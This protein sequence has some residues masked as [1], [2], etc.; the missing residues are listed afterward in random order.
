MSYCSSCGQAVGEAWAYCRYCGADL[1][2]E[3]A[4]GTGTEDPTVVLFP[5]AEETSAAATEPGPVEAETRTLTEEI[6]LER[7]TKPR[8]RTKLR[9][10]ITRP[11]LVAAAVALAAVGM[12]AVGVL[13]H[14][15][16]RNGL[17]G[18]LSDMQQQLDRRNVALAETMQSLDETTEEL[19]STRSDLGEVR[20][21]LRKA[22]RELKG[23]RGTL[24]EAQGRL[25]LQAGQIETLKSCLNGVAAAFE[26]LVY[27]DYFG[28]AGALQAVEFSCEQA[29]QL[30]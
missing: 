10:V 30:F 6:G 14:F 17:A 25:E 4:R 15:D 22:T 12:I 3:A 21:R 27:E 20:G 29:F 16:V 5:Q 7:P 2:A 13:Y 8:F 18:E 11:R 28:A 24:Q 26:S 9:R 19:T 1:K 23:V